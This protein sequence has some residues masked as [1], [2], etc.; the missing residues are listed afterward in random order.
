MIDITIKSHIG[1]VVS[2]IDKIYKKAK[3]NGKLE[4]QEIYYLNI[5]YK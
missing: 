2:S 3:L 1:V 4:I 5:I